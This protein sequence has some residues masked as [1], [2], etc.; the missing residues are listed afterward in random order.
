M[1]KALSEMSLKE[2]WELFPIFLVQHQEHWKEWYIEEESR[3]QSFL[4]L[5]EQL[6]I[7]HIGSTAINQ[8]WAKPTIDI[9]VEIPASFS[10]KCIK[11]LLV[12]NGYICMSE[13]GNRKSFNR[14]YTNEGFAERVFHL[15]LRYL[16]DNNELY[17]RDY[18][19]DY[20]AMA[21]QYEEMKLLLWKKFEHDR[22][23]YTNAKGRFISE[24]TEKAK[25]VYEN[26]Y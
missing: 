12:N 13:E 17:F 4:P 20:S 3:L 25:K 19:N 10:M 15:H 6:K 21:K 2:L 14:G 11:E 7:N 1:G 8:I 22:D 9:L 26:R 16:G 23:G 5:L 24:C 18:M